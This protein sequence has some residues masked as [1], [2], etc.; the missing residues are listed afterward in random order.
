MVDAKDGPPTRLRVRVQA[1]ASRT[2]LA[3]LDPDGRLRVRVKS[4]PVDGSANREL[5][6]FL[7]KK[8]LRVAPSSL[9][10]VSGLASRDKVIL[11][12]GMSWGTLDTALKRHL[13]G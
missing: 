13:E 5:L 6:R 1:R 12:T 9:E 7:G 2:D 4:A 3:G 11:V 10:L 8:V